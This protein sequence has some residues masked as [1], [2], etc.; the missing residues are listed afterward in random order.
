MQ[1]RRKIDFKE[2]KKRQN[3]LIQNACCKLNVLFCGI[4][5]CIY[6]N[7]ITTDPPTPPHLQNIFKFP[8]MVFSQIKFMNPCSYFFVIHVI[9]IVKLSFDVI[10]V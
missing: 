3:S 10:I 1:L 4:Y 5:Y 6:E 2:N 7:Y 9:F 8:D